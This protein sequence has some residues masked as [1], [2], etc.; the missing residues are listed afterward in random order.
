MS[1]WRAGRIDPDTSEAIE[2]HTYIDN[3]GA[4]DTVTGVARGDVGAVYP[5]YGSNRGYVATYPAAPGLRNVCTYGINVG[6]GQN[7]LLGCRQ[8]RL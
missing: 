7:V 4:E 1:P 2:V 8:I 3:R 5:A 6:A